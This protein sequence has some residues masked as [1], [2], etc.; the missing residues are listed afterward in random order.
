[1]INFIKTQQSV[2]I[3]I[4][5][6]RHHHYQPYQASPL[7]AISGNTTINHIQASPYQ[8]SPL[9]IHCHYHYRPAHDR[10]AQFEGGNNT[11]NQKVS[12]IVS[13]VWAVIIQEIIKKI[14]SKV[15]VCS[16]SLHHHESSGELINFS[17][18]FDVFKSKTKCG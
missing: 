13:A 17:I 2:I 7:S 6:I 15:S 12:K 1:M 11:N 5:H 4:S 8:A 3:T 18:V 16:L 10:L 14:I 9:S